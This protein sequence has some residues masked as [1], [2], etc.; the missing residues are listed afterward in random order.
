MNYTTV[1]ELLLDDGFWAWYHRLDA[2]QVDKWESWIAASPEHRHLVDEAIQWMTSISSPEDIRQW[3]KQTVPQSYVDSIWGHVEQATRP[4]PLLE[5]AWLHQPK[6]SHHPILLGNYL[7][8][9]WRHLRLSKTY[10]S[11]NIFGLSLGMAVTILI[12]LWV[13]DELSY[14][15]YHEHYDRIAMVMQRYTVK[16]Q[17]PGANTAVPIPLGDALRTSY[18]RD[19]KEVVMQSSI[20]TSNLS[21][22]DMKISRNGFFMERGGPDLLS[23][24]MEKGS[25]DGLKDRNSILLSA[26]TAKALFGNTDP[27]NKIVKV[28][29]RV[30]VKVTGVYEDMPSNSDFH[31]LKFLMPWDL[32]TSEWEWVHNAKNNWD[33]NAFGALVELNPGAD[34][35]KVS[36]EIRNLKREAAVT[37]DS[38]Q[39]ELF[40]FPMSR[41]HLFSAFPNGVSEG[42]QIRYVW[43]FGAIGVFVL[44]LACINFMNLSTARSERRAREVGIRKSIGSVRSQLIGQFLSESVLIALI[45]FTLALLVVWLSLPFFNRVAGKTMSVL[46]SNPWFW[47]VGLGCTLLTGLIAG[48]Y[49]AFYLSSFQPV[50]VL[51]GTFRAGRYASLPRKILVV[52]QFTVSVLLIAGT[53]IVFRQI[54]FAKDRPVGYDRSGLLAILMTTGEI[55]TNYN[56]LRNELLQ[57]GIAAGVSQTQGPVT[58]VWTGSDNFDWEGKDPRQHAGFAVIGGTVDYGATIGWQLKAGRNFSKDFPTDS[59]CVILNETAVK[60]MGLRD[61]V[62]KY[63]RWGQ[64]PNKVIGVVKDLVMTSP[65][66]TIQPTVFYLLREGGNFVYVRINPRLST[67]EALQ[68]MG[69]VFARYNP[70][71]PF[72]YRFVDELYASKFGDEERIGQLA[73]IFANLAILIS[74]LGLFGL[75][76]Y[77]AEQRSKEVGIRKVLGATVFNLWKLLSKDFVLLVLL[78]CCIAVPVTWHFLDKW[79]EQYNYRIRIT[80]DVFALV[81]AGAMS[82]ALLTVSFQAIRTALANPIGSLRNK[83]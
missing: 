73:A 32:F 69:A 81:G 36:H 79:L 50:R 56:S 68:R 1:E 7:K 70:A 47:L 44:L 55:Y 65:F 33:F 59:Q 77:T 19:F 76:S 60:L 46:W 51:K 13:W 52:V 29:N 83:E 49:P 43:L 42:G 27:I 31:D 82:V 21:F 2:A 14:N 38:T 37:V 80:W 20:S 30:N 10:S 71:A 25:R 62:G 26:T 15:T 61:A 12:G 45:S 5:R 24:Q 16:G 28:N 3:E 72:E 9:A 11:I 74:C 41:W 6:R 48:S 8:V 22:Q 4:K 78:S 23:L 64:A 67:H 54:K 34:P 17:P 58:D 57:T 75:S 53:I 63:I 66:Q 40:L 35:D 18:G 39:S